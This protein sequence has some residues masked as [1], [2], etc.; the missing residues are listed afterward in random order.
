MLEGPMIMENDREIFSE[1]FRK[2]VIQL[3]SS[4]IKITEKNPKK[5]VKWAYLETFEVQKWLKN[6]F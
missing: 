5:W 3:R 6:H 2:T 4:K 1:F